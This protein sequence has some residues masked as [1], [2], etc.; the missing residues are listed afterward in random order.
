MDKVKDHVDSEGMDE[1]KMTKEIEA[2]ETMA[3]GSEF[4][5]VGLFKGKKNKEIDFGKSL[6]EF[7]KE[8][9]FEEYNSEVMLLCS[10]H[11]DRHYIEALDRV[12]VGLC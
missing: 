10:I 11:V 1:A 12:V 8:H 3:G 6:V 7:Q 4:C 9:K 2:G 5:R